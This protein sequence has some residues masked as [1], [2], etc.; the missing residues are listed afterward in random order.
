VTDR[1]HLILDG[2][3]VCM[4]KK[5]VPALRAARRMG[6]HLLV[7]WTVD[8]HTCPVCAALARAPAPGRAPGLRPATWHP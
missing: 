3:I 2:N 1:A 6:V 8:G 4:Q 5:L 7:T